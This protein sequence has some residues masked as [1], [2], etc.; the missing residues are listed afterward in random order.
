MA[1]AK[2][3]KC[4]KCG[5]KFE[6]VKQQHSCAV[7]PVAKHLKGKKLAT[8]LYD[9]LKLKIKKTAGPFYVESLPCCIHFVTAAFTFSAVYA[10]KDGL[11]LHFGLDHKISSKRIRRYSQIAA[12]R[13]MYELD[14]KD[15]NEMDKE[16]LAWLKEAYSTKKK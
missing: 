2:L 12:S 15:K 7:Y 10:M 1:A 14:I 9:E 6:K 13:Y 5:R 16:L 8:E 4:P 3:W 11:R